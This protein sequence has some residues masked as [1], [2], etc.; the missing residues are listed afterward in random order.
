MYMY[1]TSSP[2][3]VGRRSSHPHQQTNKKEARIANSAYLVVIVVSAALLYRY[4]SKISAFPMTNTV[5]RIFVLVLFCYC[6]S[7]SLTVQPLSRS[8]RL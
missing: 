1:E 2:A 8:W 3:T 6:C 4:L 5:D 7:S